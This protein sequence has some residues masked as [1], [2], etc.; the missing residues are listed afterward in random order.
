MKLIFIY[1]EQVESKWPHLLHLKVDS[2]QLW[3]SFYRILRDV[4][5]MEL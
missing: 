5:T 1:L 4:S 2:G 3:L